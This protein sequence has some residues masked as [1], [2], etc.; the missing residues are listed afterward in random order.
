MSGSLVNMEMSGE[1]QWRMLFNSWLKPL[2][3]LVAASVVCSVLS[4]APWLEVSLPVCG[5]MLGVWLCR[6]LPALALSCTEEDS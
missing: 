4:L 2:L 3:A 5:F 6:E 1:D